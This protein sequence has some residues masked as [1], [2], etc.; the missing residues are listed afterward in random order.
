MN[1]DEYTHKRDLSMSPE[2]AA[3]YPSVKNSL[4]LPIFVVQKHQATHLH[5]DLRLE[6]DGVLKSW[7][8]PKGPSLDPSQKRLAIEVEDHPLDYRNFEGVIPSGNYGAGAVMLWDEGTYL[9][10][11]CNDSEC[12]QQLLRNSFK[13]GNL[14]FILDGK[15]LKGAFH[16]VRLNRK[17]TSEQWLLIKK[18]DSFSSN[19]DILLMNRSVRTGRTIEEITFKSASSSTLSDF[20][21]LDLSG[22]VNQPLPTNPI[23]PMLAR[24]IASPFDG[25]DW[26]FEIKWDGYRAIAETR[27]NGLLFYSRHANSFINDYSQIADELSQIRFEAIFD[28]E[29]VALDTDGRADFGA[30]QNYQRTKKGLLIYFIFDLLYFEGY[31]LKNLPLYKRKSILKQI[32]PP[33]SHI[34]YCEHIEKEGKA[35]FNAAKENHLEGIVAKN[36]N[37]PYIPG[38]RS[39]YWQKIK[40]TLN[41]EF[42]IG[43]FTE[44][45][46]SR[47]GI[48]SLLLGVYDNS[49]LIYVGNVGSGFTSEEMLSLRETLENLKT[50]DSPFKSAPFRGT[51]C[52]WIRPE[53]VCEVQ[54]AEWTSDGILRHPAFKGFRTDISAQNV[55]REIPSNINS[56]DLKLTHAYDK[57]SFVKIDD[58]TLKLTNINKIYWSQQG[59]TKGNMITYYQMVCDWILPHLFDRPQSL[60]RFPDGIDGKHFYHKDIENAPEWISTISISSDTDNKTIKYL[61]CQNR[62]SLIYIANLGALE[63]NPW[64]S[65][66]SHLDYPDYMII[67]LDP[68]DCPF[69]QVTTAAMMVHEILTR[70]DTPHYLKTSGATGLHICVPLGA[71]YTYKQSRQFAMIICSL[72]NKRLSKITSME[73]I[74]E[75]RKGMV[76]LDYLQNIKGKTI[77]APYS[78]RPL[79]HATVSTPLK[80]EELQ[81]KLSPEQFTIHNIKERLDSFGDLWKPVIGQGINMQK[82]LHTLSDVFDI[83]EKNN[84]K[85]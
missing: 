20:T 37:S 77:A 72:V 19:N 69:E 65:R 81:M 1:L 75:N 23:T 17:D 63:F 15:K 67:D 10:P 32:L 52:I 47:T 85:I 28:G 53:L 33:F 76:Y 83:R 66:V 7:A 61:L 3:S 82:S 43:G 39:Q 46:S 41:Q 73:R 40:I 11:N 36:K 49:D 21:K 48:G 22:A 12:I 29:I 8:V 55:I 70:I 9:V 34:H 71:Q 26:F 60:H 59:I 50:K 74:P 13:K 5:Y 42:V 44:P 78:L 30:L 84:D 58:V 14:I 62:A 25:D 2:P 80:W 16:L 54:F 51:E 4:A 31:D 27:K 24:L 18:E 6:L 56:A 45:R 35:F 38:N 79:P 64:I 68:L 57:D